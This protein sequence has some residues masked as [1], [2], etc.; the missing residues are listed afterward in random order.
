MRKSNAKAEPV[1]MRLPKIKRWRGGGLAAPVSD[2]L[3]SVQTKGSAHALAG[4]AYTKVPNL[5]TDYPAPL[6]FR[7][8]PPKNLACGAPLRIAAL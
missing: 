3:W 4:K 1:E 5:Y 7:K 6:F 2:V 8:N